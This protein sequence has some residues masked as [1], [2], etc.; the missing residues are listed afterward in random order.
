MINIIIYGLIRC[1][2]A[3]Y[4]PMRNLVKIG[5]FKHTVAKEKLPND[6]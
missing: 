4:T 1:Y 2:Y 5:T 6:H 3:Y